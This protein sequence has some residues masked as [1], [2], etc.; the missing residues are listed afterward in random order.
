M[1]GNWG[2]VAAAAFAA[3]SALAQ[4]PATVEALDWMSGAWVSEAE[5]RWTE[6]HWTSPRGGLMLGVNRSGK[7][8]KAGAFEFLR[9]SPGKEGG[10]SYYAAPGGQP[11]VEFKL[12]SASASEVLF[13]NPGNDYPTR[14]AYRRD[15]DALV[16]T[17]SGPD[18]G[19]PMSWTFRRR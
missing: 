16:A 1:R 3:S 10:V 2:F 15:G 4:A 7:A 9:I 14:I 18:G 11:P 13:E 19:N 6:E 17:I 8:D 5:G 12:V